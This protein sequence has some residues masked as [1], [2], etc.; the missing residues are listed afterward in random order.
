MCSVFLLKTLAGV[1]EK[2]CCY[3]RSANVYITG[4]QIIFFDVLL[5]VTFVVVNHFQESVFTRR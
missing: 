2:S 1:W 5:N 3:E 4:K